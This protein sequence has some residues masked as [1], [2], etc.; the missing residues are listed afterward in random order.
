MVGV[1][2]RQSSVAMSQYAAARHRPSNAASS[3]ESPSSPAT[4]F[5]T[6]LSRPLSQPLCAAIFVANIEHSRKCVVLIAKRHNSNR[7]FVDFFVDARSM[8]MRTVGQV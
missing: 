1:Q 6:A 2:T 5:V 4:V 7:T 3:A 8:P